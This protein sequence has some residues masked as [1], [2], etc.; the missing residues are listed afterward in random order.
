MLPDFTKLPSIMS[1]DEVEKYFN[2]IM[3]IAES[4][5]TISPYLIQDTLNDGFSS[6]EYNPKGKFGNAI[7]DRIVH[8][9]QKNW[10]WPNGDIEYIDGLIFL[11]INFATTDAS[12]AFFQS[13]LKS[14]KR[15]FV[16]AELMDVLTNDV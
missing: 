14:D 6:L 12:K 13:R 1:Y 10:N 9:V 2:L 3:G 15:G 4:D 16:Q 8:W 11:H 5:Q 7:S